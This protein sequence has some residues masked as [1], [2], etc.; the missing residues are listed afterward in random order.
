MS[1][2]YIS[3]NLYNLYIEQNKTCT[4]SQFENSRLCKYTGREG[5][6]SMPPRRHTALGK[7]TWT[8][9][10]KQELCH[11]RNTGSRERE[12][13][14]EGSARICMASDHSSVQ[15]SF[16]KL[17]WEK[18]SSYLG[19]LP[20]EKGRQVQWDEFRQPNWGCQKWL[21]HRDYQAVNGGFTERAGSS[22]SQ[23]V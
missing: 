6:I 23:A 22:T 3:F 12:R 8:L 18:N 15:F 16:P 7:P 5:F 21:L 4:F 1:N 17:F 10:D 20:P 19:P 2:Y 9:W 13:D 11:Q 14:L